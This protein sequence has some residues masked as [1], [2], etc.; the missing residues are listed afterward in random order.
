MKGY[1]LEKLLERLGLEY[2]E[3]NG[4][5]KPLHPDT[6]CICV[7][8][9]NILCEACWNVFKQGLDEDSYYLELGKEIFGS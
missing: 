3:C 4:C 7:G 8:R 9:E 2:W 6:P 5:D 1:G